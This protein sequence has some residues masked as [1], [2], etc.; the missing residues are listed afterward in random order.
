[1]PGAGGGHVGDD[2]VGAHG[3]SAD[4]FGFN[5][6][7]FQQLEDCVA[8]QPSAFGVEGCG[9]TVYVVVAGAAGGELELAEPE[10]EAGEERE[11]LLRVGRGSHHSRL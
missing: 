4:G 11:Q 8:G 1:M 3:E 2:G 7:L 9:A 6:L 5:F 10:A